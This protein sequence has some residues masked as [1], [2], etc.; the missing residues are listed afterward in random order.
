MENRVQTYLLA[1]MVISTTILWCILELNFGYSLSRNRE[2]IRMR[3]N[4]ENIGKC[5]FEVCS[6]KQVKHIFK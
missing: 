5:A 6:S 1:K 4:D 3:R 2:Q